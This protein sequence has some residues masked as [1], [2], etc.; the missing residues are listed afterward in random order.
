[1]SVKTIENESF[2]YASTL[3]RVVSN[4]K[5]KLGVDKL[6]LTLSRNL[7]MIENQI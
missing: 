6:T 3:G 5:A 7:Q 2:D 4:S 1:V